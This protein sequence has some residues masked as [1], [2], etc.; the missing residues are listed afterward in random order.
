VY[1]T[2]STGSFRRHD[3]LALELAFFPHSRLK[4]IALPASCLLPARSQLLANISHLILIDP[5]MMPSLIWGV[6]NLI[7]HTPYHFKFTYVGNEPSF[8]RAIR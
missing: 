8:Y 6:L 2:K 5:I 7:R 1:I 3:L 4:N